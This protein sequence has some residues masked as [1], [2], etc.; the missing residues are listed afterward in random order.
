MDKK[1]MKSSLVVVDLKQAEIEIFK[2]TQTNYYFE[3]NTSLEKREEI[4]I[5]SS[6]TL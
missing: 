2:I 1:M 4:K 6:L 5:S 3:E